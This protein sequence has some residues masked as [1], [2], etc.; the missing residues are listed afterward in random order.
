MSLITISQDFGSEGFAIAKK[1]AEMLNLELYDDDRIKEEALKEGIREEYLKGLEE[2][3]PGFFDRLKGRKPD[4]YLDVLQSVVYRISKQGHGVIVGH[5]SQMLL[6]DFGCALHVR[7][8]GSGK[9]RARKMAEQRGISYEAARKIIMKKDDELKGFF[10]FA[11]QMDPNDPGLYD[12]IL[13]M[14][15]ISME[16]AVKYI[17]DLARSDDIKT[18]SL[19]ALE[20]MER[21]S[22]ERKVHAALLEHMLASRIFT[23][24]VTAPGTV[25]IYGIA[26]SE[27]EKAKVLDIIGNMKEINKVES[28]LVVVKEGL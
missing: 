11:F 14:E 12:L 27:D 7:I 10:K 18:C 2:K 28:S 4:I 3:A 20:S 9:T 25:T 24:E 1:I 19:S 6:K 5:G 13:N 16:T 21:L 26:N 22:L 8:Y 15:K 17:A 23:V